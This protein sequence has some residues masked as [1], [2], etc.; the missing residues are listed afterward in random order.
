MQKK[1][2]ALHV[3]EKGKDKKE[4][5]VRISSR[6]QQWETGYW[7]INDSTAESLIGGNI[8]VHKGQKIP[9]HIG[10][11]ILSYRSEAGGRKVFRFRADA[12]LTNVIATSGWGNE[13]RIV[14]QNSPLELEY[15][16][17]EDDESN[18]P[19]GAEAYRVHRSRERDPKLAGRAKQKRFNETGSLKCDVCS[20]DF[21]EEFGPLGAGYIEAHHTTPVVQLA[22]S[23]RTKLSELV[24][25][26]SNCHR[27]LHRSNPMLDVLGLRKLRKDISGGK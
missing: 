1:A 10:G 21:V 23:R 13:K 15:F 7:K 6:S 26:C 2:L 14:W 17:S 5:L 19:E 16:H 22:G 4:N 12:R 8:Y 20:F 3:I 25:V 11:K 9:S 18:F 27:M 24:L